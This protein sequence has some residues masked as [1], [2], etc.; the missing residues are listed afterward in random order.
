MTRTEL[1]TKT[2]NYVSTL[3]TKDNG[4]YVSTPEYNE[5]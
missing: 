4:D 3:A 5:Q 1:K 2:S